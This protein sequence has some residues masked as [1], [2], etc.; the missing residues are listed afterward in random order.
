MK[1]ITKILIT[2]MILPLTGCLKRDTME[3]INIYTTVYPIEYITK[4]LYG[5]NS[6]INSIYPSG[7]IPEKYSLT[8]KQIKDYSKSN[9]FV[10]N[11]LSNEKNYLKS[12]LKYNDQL[13]I[14]DST[15]S[16]EYE[17]KMEQLWLDPSNLLMISRNIKTGLNEYINNHYI[18]E[19]IETNYEKL[20]IELSGLAA[21]LHLI[22][23]SVEDTTIVVSNDLFKYL[24]H[25]NFNVISL[26][27]NEEL[28]DKKIIDVKKRIATGATKYIIILQNEIPNETINKIINETGVKTLSFH[29]LENIS[30]SER[31]SKKDYISIMNENINLLKQELYK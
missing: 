3:D 19:E 7:I 2:L 22:S 6:T 30:E 16:M 24:N 8:E 25:Y 11:G 23:S 13:K 9:L 1:K 10:F 29:T 18:K 5:K 14:I 15:L 17:D 31:I 27:E 21:K 4:K 28:T 26:E 12:M 20:K